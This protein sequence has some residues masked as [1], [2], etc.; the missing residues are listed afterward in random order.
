MIIRHIPMDSI[1]KSKFTNLVRYITNGQGKQER[2]GKIRISNCSSVDPH[3]AALE[4]EATQ[5]RNKRAQGDKS[6]HLLISFA[7]G[8]CPESEVL[9]TI[10]EKVVG[11]IGFS[12]HQ[13]ISTVH[14]DT[15]NLHIH[16]AINKIHPIHFTMKEPYQAYKQFSKVA[17][18]LEDEFSLIKTNHQGK[19][20]RAEN[21][22][23][24]M[25]HHA[26]IESL[27]NWVK[28]HCLDTLREC[29][30]WASLHDTLAA[31]DLALRLRGNGL[32]VESGF[33]ISI[34]AS[35]LSREFSKKKLE[36][37]LG[38]FQPLHR[39]ISINQ[40][41]A[42][43]PLQQGIKANSLYKKYLVEKETHYKLMRDKLVVLRDKK[44]RLIEQA[45]TKGKLK[46]ATVKLV[47][48]SR[49]EKKLLYESIHQSLKNDIRQVMKH[50]RQDCKYE[51]ER[52]KSCTW[53]DWLQKKAE[54]GDE[55]A[56]TLMRYN[57]QTHARQYALSGHTKNSTISLSKTIDSVT[58]EGTVI[59]KIKTCTIRDTGREIS[60]SKGASPEGLKEALL[61]AKKRFGNCIAV[62]GSALFKQAILMVAVRYELDIKFD[63]YG[64]E[65]QRQ[66]LLSIA[67]DRNEQSRRA[68]L[69]HGRATGRSNEIVATTPGSKRHRIKPVY[70]LPATTRT[71][72]K[73]N[74]GRTGQCPPP[75]N[76]NRLRVLSEL[77][78]VQL[79]GGSKMLLQT[80]VHDQ[81]ERKRTQ[82]D[83]SLRRP[84]P[85]LS[86]TKE[87]KKR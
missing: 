48:G 1:K 29:R 53:A 77:P 3:W 4:V 59:H 35:S 42:L 60:I 50:Y 34:K 40:S 47:N 33:G 17:I 26:G 30:D 65:L 84:I 71:R 6:Y 87:R 15:D 13:R 81:L 61:L 56:L 12:A 32:I 18:Q 10:E 66:H 52:Y 62:N 67:G 2:V 23:D 46:R 74:V 7:K 79:T 20:S 31:H 28:R 72:T 70:S 54:K 69:I 16:V 43:R 21:R 73:S 44:N 14:H 82:P 37:R 5:S 41:Y 55:D 11:S 36:D 83:N 22:A 45:K 75:E 58:K 25:E 68:G 19:K 64:L 38:P 63:D 85:H 86:S 24:D 8:E 76:N 27:I 9:R 51:V 57:P 80:H 78:V 49:E 39:E